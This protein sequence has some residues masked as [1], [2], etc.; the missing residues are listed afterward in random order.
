MLA[1]TRLFLAAALAALGASMPACSRGNLDRGARTTTSSA[2]TTRP[3]RRV[4]QSRTIDNAGFVDN[5]G[6]TSEQTNRTES[7]GMRATETGSERPT[8]TASGLPLP[9]EPTGARG[10]SEGERENAGGEGPGT[11][12]RVPGA[13]AAPAAPR[14]ETGP[15]A[16][17]GPPTEAIGRLARA[18]CDHA[19]A[20][21]D[22]GTGRAWGSQESC[23][24]EQRD[25]ARA[26]VASLGCRR[27]VDRT[28]LA[29]CL[30]S[31]RLQGCDA[32]GVGLDEVPECR[33]T[34]LCVP[35]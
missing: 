5:A 15:V 26:D 1:S 30:I 18:R 17:G 23:V 20:C 11:A 3:D 33:T 25:Q 10:V 8:G 34:A 16:T 22:V 14:A 31:I 27:G 13:P 19:T 2:S 21:N 9:A 35:W 12:P 29:T 4:P 7:S 6:R 28:Q 32:R 24:V